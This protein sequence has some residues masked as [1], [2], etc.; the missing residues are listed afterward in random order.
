M[1]GF[2]LH[3]T[4]FLEEF[5]GTHFIQVVTPSGY[6]TNCYN[7]SKNLMLYRFTF[8]FNFFG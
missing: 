4:K 8:V 1:N 6:V 3:N 2:V 5:F 7:G